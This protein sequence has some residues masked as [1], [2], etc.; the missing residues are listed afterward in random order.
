MVLV[1]MVL[2]NVLWFG[3]LSVILV[4]GRLELILR[5]L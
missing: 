2:V 1:S 4:F 5:W 3:L